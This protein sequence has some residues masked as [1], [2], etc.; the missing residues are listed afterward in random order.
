MHYDTLNY[1]PQSNPWLVGAFSIIATSKWK[2]NSLNKMKE[3]FATW[4]NKILMYC[5][6]L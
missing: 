1:L 3:A 6:F 2:V 5:I 4:A